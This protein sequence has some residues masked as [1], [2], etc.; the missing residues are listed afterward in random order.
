MYLIIILLTAVPTSAIAHDQ[1]KRVDW[2]DT[3]AGRWLR[4]YVASFSSDGEKPLIEFAEKHYS[5][6]YREKETIQQIIKDHESVRKQI[7][8]LT[9]ASA[10]ADGD[11]K[12]RVVARS[13]KV[14]IWLKISLELKAS[15]P[16]DKKTITIVPTRGPDQAPVPEYDNGWTTVDELVQRVHA[17]SKAP[18]LAVAVIWRGKLTDRAVSGIRLVGTEQEAMIED[19]FHLGSI[20]KSVTATVA[21]RLVERKVLS[22]GMTVGE[23][24]K[25][26][27]IRDDLKAVTLQQLLRHRSGI[28]SQPEGLDMARGKVEVKGPIEGRRMT[29]AAALSTPPMAAPGEKYSYSNAGYT[30][31]GHLIETVAKKSWE[32]LVQQEVH[33]PLTLGS[34]G[35][36]WPATPTRL[37]QPRGHFGARTD[38]VVQKVDEG[39][40]GDIDLATFLAPA[41][42]VHMSVSDLARF[43]AM[44]LAGLRGGKGHLS[45]ATIRHLH[46]PPKGGD[47]ALGWVIEKT[48][49]G[50]PLHWHNG[51]GGSFYAYLALYPE[52][53]LVIAAVTNCGPTV[54]PW[55]LKMTQA[56][57]AR[58]LQE[59]DR[60]R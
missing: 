47:Y 48:R 24:F 34:A 23:V 8:A 58:R 33:A 42:D 52:S 1:E 21:A 40:M 43:G 20:T 38:L 7:G 12:V 39:M 4:D 32:E 3:P 35:F 11:Y 50:K 56:I 49:D 18:A 36:G 28:P 30:V 59:G 16:H 37:D 5:K 15:A 57:R 19:R 54:Q 31:A 6:E 27:E 44:H 46:T 9:V 45:P 60:V 22:W 10:T 29:T 14:G 26:M 13:Q 41:G 55:I 51:S 25:D 2:P 17:D 53:D